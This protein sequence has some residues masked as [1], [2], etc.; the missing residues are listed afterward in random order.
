MG[1]R[2]WYAGDA[3][4]FITNQFAHFFLPSNAQEK[5][6]VLKNIK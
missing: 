4:Y 2:A 3:L 5:V 6:I 1:S